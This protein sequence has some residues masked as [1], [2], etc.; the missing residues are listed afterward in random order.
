ML[1]LLAA[2]GLVAPIGLALLFVLAPEAVRSWVDDGT[3]SMLAAIGAGTVGV[4]LTAIVVFAYVRLRFLRLIRTAER[5]ATGEESV[6]VKVPKNGLEAQLGRALDGIASQMA[7]KH[8]EATIDK[9]TGVANR[10]ALLMALFTEVDRAARYNRP[11]SV[12][13]VDIDHFKAVND[14]YGHAVGDVVL[15]AVAQAIKENLR[16]TDMV[17]PTAARSSCSS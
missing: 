1:R 14:T 15:R 8:A 2:L 10:Q 17:G 16:G 3:T 13:F 12:A 9:L 11:L 4:S 7:T 5:I 6:K